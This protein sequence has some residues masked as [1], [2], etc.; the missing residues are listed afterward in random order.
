M[1]VTTKTKHLKTKEAKFT[2]EKT[3]AVPISVLQ[4]ILDANSSEPLEDWLMVTDEKSIMQMTKAQVALK[5]GK[6]IPWERVK[7]Q[8]GIK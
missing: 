6:G 1:A 7:E 3:L 5:S 2:T 4:Q 8:L